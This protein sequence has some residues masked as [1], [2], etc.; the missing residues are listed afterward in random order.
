MRVRVCGLLDQREACVMKKFSC[1]II[2]VLLVSICTEPLAA[3]TQPKKSAAPAL[4]QPKFVPTNSRPPIGLRGGQ[5]GPSSARATAS[6]R[7]RGI[8]RD[9]RRWTDRDRAAWHGGRAYHQCRFGRCGYWWWAGGYWYFYSYSVYGAPDQVS[10]VAY[11]DQGNSVQTEAE[12]PAG[13][14]YG[15]GIAPPS[16][17]DPS[18]AAGAIIG[19]AIGGMLGNALGGR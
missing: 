13:T 5:A 16:E 12:Q 10:E 8:D 2:A 17:V 9:P 15:P 4:T 3:A 1:S 14:T 19:G 6:A 7:H 11:D 18:A